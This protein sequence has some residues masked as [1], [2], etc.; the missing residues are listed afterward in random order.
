MKQEDRK[1][2]SAQEAKLLDQLE[3]LFSD[4]RNAAE[5]PDGFWF[6]PDGFYPNYLS[7]NPKILYIARDSYDLYGDVDAFGEKTYIEKFLRQ[8]LLGRVDDGGNPNG[9][10]I[11]SAK[12]H[13]MLI[14]VAYGI[15]HECSWNQSA[16]NPSKPWVP[17]ASEIC[18]GGKIFEKVSFAFM[19]LCKWSHESDDAGINA[20]WDAISEFV[21]KSVTG[22]TNYIL[23]EISLLSPD[24]IITMNLGPERIAHFSQGKAKLIDDKNP[25]CYV[26]Q[27][28][29][30]KGSIAL[31]DTW[32]FSS[33]KDEKTEIYNPL[34]KQIDA[35]W[36]NKK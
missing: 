33:S 35:Y 3:K 16:D 13:K 31:F 26:Y 29:T 1:K 18:D 12:F 25:N 9:K 36:R 30:N 10:S 32:H 24:I 4:W 34:A 6:V 28:E 21:E 2:Y 11:N 8:Y 7:Q 22:G 19:N 27:L 15:L 14:Q 17:S 20:A 5:E 23:E